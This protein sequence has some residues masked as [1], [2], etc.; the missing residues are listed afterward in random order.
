MTDTTTESLPPFLDSFPWIAEAV[1]T[2]ETQRPAS[3][4]DSDASEM[5]QTLE[6]LCTWFGPFLPRPEYLALAARDLAGSEADSLTGLEHQ[7]PA[8]L[9]GDIRFLI[10]YLAVVGAAIEHLNEMEA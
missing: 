8:A 10:Q 6:T 1:A 4:E 3:W 9:L 2:A 5:L 7:T